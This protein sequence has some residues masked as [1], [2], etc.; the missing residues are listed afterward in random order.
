MPIVIAAVISSTVTPRP[1]VAS[2]NAGG[3]ITPAVALLR[4]P[5]TVR[6]P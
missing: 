1:I 2:I 4:A 3:G 6:N 5:V